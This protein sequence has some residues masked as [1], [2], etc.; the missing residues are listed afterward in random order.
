MNVKSR[1]SRAFID[2]RELSREEWRPGK[3][4]FEVVFLKPL[5]GRFVKIQYGYL[6]EQEETELVE[7][8][9]ICLTRKGKCQ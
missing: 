2:G 6:I 7:V 8:G 4:A 3:G 1:V 9:N 5:T